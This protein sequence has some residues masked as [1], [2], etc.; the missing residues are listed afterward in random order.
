MF[1]VESFGSRST[2]WVRT[3]GFRFSVQGQVFNSR[4]RSNSKSPTPPQTYTGA[5]TL[6]PLCMRRWSWKGDDILCLFEGRH[7]LNPK[8][9]AYGVGLGLGWLI[10]HN[11][12]Q[13]SESTQNL[14]R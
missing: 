6:N 1:R 9:N 3:V 10:I 13:A 12:P 2:G 4:L 5:Q 7:L 14:R 11:A 8:L